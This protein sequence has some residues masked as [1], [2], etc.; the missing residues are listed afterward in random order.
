MQMHESRTGENVRKALSQELE[1][2]S[3]YRLYAKKAKAEGY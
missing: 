3:L 1:L 2:S